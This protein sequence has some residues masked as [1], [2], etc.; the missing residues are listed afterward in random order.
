LAASADGR[1]QA[2][3]PKLSVVIS[4]EEANLKACQLLLRIEVALR[5]SLR[6]SLTKQFGPKWRT[7]LPGDLLTKIREAQKEE[8][9]PQFG[10]VC[11]GPLYYLTLGEL[12]P[13]LRQQ[14]GKSTAAS[15]GGNSF[16]EQVEN[17]LG[18]RNAIC[19]AQEIPLAG[20]KAIEALYQQMETV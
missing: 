1:E 14:A 13:I 9:K 19:H 20:L 7:R 4:F 3:K 8:K 5:E 15:F 17:I 12:V 2:T 10:Y 11:L 16:I 6:M 18:P